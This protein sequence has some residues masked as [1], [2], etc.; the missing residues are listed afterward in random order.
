MNSGNICLFEMCQKDK[1]RQEKQKKEEKRSFQVVADVCHH[2]CYRKNDW[3]LL[4]SWKYAVVSRSVIPVS[5]ATV[6]IYL[7]GICMQDV[8]MP[9]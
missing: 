2:K 3:A 4:R 9:V 8:D 1:M 5:D 7:D 6:P